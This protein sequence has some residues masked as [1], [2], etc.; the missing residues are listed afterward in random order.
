VAAPG[1]ARMTWYN[2]TKA[3]VVNLT[4]SMAAELAPDTSA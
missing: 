3:A 1:H 4:Q 2:A